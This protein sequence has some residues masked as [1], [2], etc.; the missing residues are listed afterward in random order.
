MNACVKGG[1]WQQALS[2]SAKMPSQ[3]VCP[4]VISRS[5]AVSACE[6]GGQWQQALSLPAEMPSQSVCSNVI[7]WS[8]AVSTC[9]K[10]EQWQQALL[11]EMLS[12][13][14]LSLVLPSPMAE[15]VQPTMCVE[16][17]ICPFPPHEISPAPHKN[18]NLLQNHVS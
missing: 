9:V 18:M 11:A 3:K 16:T 13:K 1:Q 14:V 17:W 12:L 6:I 4:N 5:A 15:H 7:S 8:A 10:G 2:L